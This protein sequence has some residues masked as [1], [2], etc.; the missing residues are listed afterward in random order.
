M[1]RLNSD[2]F[3]I[4]LITYEREHLFFVPAIHE[5]GE[6]IRTPIVK[7]EALR[8]I[9]QKS[10]IFWMLM[11]RDQVHGESS[12]ITCVLISLILSQSNEDLSCVFSSILLDECSKNNSGKI[13]SE[14]STRDGVKRV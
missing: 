3:Y 13:D 1:F 4:L 5:R 12:H 6:K 14:K 8:I 9:F 10:T 7:D 11:N 2:A